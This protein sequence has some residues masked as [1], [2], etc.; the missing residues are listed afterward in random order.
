MTKSELER[1]LRLAARIARDDE[2]YLIGS[3]AVYGYCPRP[4]AEVRLSQERDL[5]PKNRPEAANLI[6]GELG[7]RSRFARDH[8]FYVDVVT[9]ELA[10]LPQG[11]QRRL[12]PLRV[13]RITALCLEVHDL[14]ISKLAAGRLKDLEFVGALLRLRLADPK[15]V[16]KRIGQCPSPNERARLRVRLQAV[17]ADLR[18]G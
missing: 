14:L 13:G 5:Y 8:G 3:Q 16:R 2:F 7:R 17:V 6:N 15:V 11:W 10:T 12:K 4:P 1:A 18:V 9:P